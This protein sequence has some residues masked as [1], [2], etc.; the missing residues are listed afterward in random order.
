M[1][2]KNSV[3]TCESNNNIINLKSKFTVKICYKKISCIELFA[4]ICRNGTLLEKFHSSVK[5]TPAYSDKLKT[6][7]S[8]ASS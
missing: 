5:Y 4:Q 3:W 2:Q 7:V 6:P 8:S 1:E